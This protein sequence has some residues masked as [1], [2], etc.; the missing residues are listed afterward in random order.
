MKAVILLAGKGSRMRPLTHVVPKPLLRVAGR[1]VLDYLLD[2]LRALGVSETIFVVGHLRD[3]IQAHVTARYPDLRA[4]YVV[5]EVQDGTAG[6]LALTRPWA[7]DELLIVLADA[8]FEVEWGLT[9]T[10][11]PEKAGIIWA[12]RVEDY[13]R[14]GVIVTDESGDLVR[15]VEKPREPLSTLANIGLYYIRDHELLFEGVSHVLNSP[16]APSCEYY[17]TDAFQYMADAGAK[18]AAA[19]VTGWH[20]TG[21]PETLLAANR[22]LL[23]RDRGGALNGAAVRESRVSP[24]ARIE[25]G[26][27][28]ARSRLGDNVTV[29]EGARVEDSDLDDVIVGAG[30]VVAGSRLRASIIGSRAAVRGH[31]GSVRVASDSEVHSHAS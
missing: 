22:Y 17:L 23:G 10:L 8:V 4:R 6:A 15:I 30:A 13:Q 21:K 14:F 27:V 9:R 7:C 18:L 28:V 5:Q 1:P 31:S 12:K 29:E 24:V 26:A 25:A 20:D 3:A 2:D 11:A 19:P 16:P